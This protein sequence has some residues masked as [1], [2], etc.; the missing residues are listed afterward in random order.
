VTVEVLRDP[1]FRTSCI[2]N[3]ATSE[4]EKHVVYSWYGIIQPRDNH[5]AHQICELDH[6]VD[7]GA[8]GADTLDNI[9]PQCGPEGASVDD[10][11]F[12]AKDEVEVWQ[13]RGIKAGSLNQSKSQEAIARDWSALL[14]PNP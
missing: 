6:L 14:N 2:R 7:L 11:Y 1:S 13:Q 12:H 9:W 8:G 10:T 4:E 5:G 3:K